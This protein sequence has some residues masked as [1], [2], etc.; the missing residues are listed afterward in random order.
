MTFIINNHNNINGYLV[1]R[2]NYV[3]IMR[4][5]LQ[6]KNIY[7]LKDILYVW[8]YELYWWTWELNKKIY[9]SVV[10]IFHHFLQ[11][12]IIIDM[13]VWTFFLLYNIDKNLVYNAM[14]ITIKN[15]STFHSFIISYNRHK[16][17]R[18]I[19]FNMTFQERKQKKQGQSE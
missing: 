12:K 4:Y 5:E 14:Y 18:V 19:S 16:G 13:S 3:I 8:K 9:G 2:I 17:I 10:G 7:S 1:L 15:E 11:A 6:N